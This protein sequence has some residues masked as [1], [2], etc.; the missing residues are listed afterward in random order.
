MP[1]RMLD[2]PL[3]LWIGV[4]YPF[5]GMLLDF[6]N[7][8]VRADMGIMK[9]R[10]VSSQDAAREDPALAGGARPPAACGRLLARLPLGAWSR[11]P[12]RVETVRC[13]PLCGIQAWTSYKLA[14]L[15]G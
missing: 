13:P 2:L 7:P 12:H 5:P 8:P 9:W 10:F 11:T 3:E 4:R 6:R 14:G 15:T 1:R